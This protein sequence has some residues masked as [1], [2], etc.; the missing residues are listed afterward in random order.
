MYA[1][2]N[3]FYNEKT[4][5]I[6][7]GLEPEATL[8]DSSN[9]LALEWTPH[10][11]FPPAFS[12]AAPEIHFSGLAVARLHRRPVVHAPQPS[13]AA[14]KETCASMGASCTGFEFTANQCVSRIFSVCFILW[15]VKM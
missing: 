12:T 10:P 11:R 9:S 6:F 3:Y 5:E 1:A 15:G 14:C 4:L 8:E 2:T 13:L 7:L